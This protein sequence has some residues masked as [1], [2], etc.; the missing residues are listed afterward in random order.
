MSTLR[1]MYKSLMEEQGHLCN[2]REPHLTR[3]REHLLSLL[4]E[5][6]E[7]SQGNEIYISHN[8]KVA[9]LLMKAHDSQ[10]DQDDALLLMRAAVILHKNC[11]AKP[12]PFSG[13]FSSYCLSSPVH[14]KLRIFLFILNFKF[15]KC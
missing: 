3:F 1:K 4:P 12:E 11:L 15:S 7:F 10:I 6:T 13:S 8:E 5:W 2:E 14:D 9:D